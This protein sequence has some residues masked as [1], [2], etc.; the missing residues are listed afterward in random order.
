MLYAGLCSRV[1][2]TAA[3]RIAVMSARVEEQ[4][5]DDD[6]FLFCVE[7]KLWHDAPKCA[8]T[9]SARA[10]ALWAIPEKARGGKNSRSTGYRN[11]T[12]YL[13]RQGKWMYRVV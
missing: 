13:K 9:V 12:H 5:D 10:R 8:F 11:I 3:S 1:F 6:R 4:R 7:K 2:M